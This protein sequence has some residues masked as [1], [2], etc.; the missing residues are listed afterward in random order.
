MHSNKLRYIFSVIFGTALYALTVVLFLLPADLPTGGT[1]GIALAIQH[2]TFLPISVFTFLFNTIMLISGWI[3]LGRVFA[4]T[5]VL[6][7]LTYPLALSLFQKIFDGVVL[8]SNPLLCTLYTGLGI[9]ISLAIV[10]RQG[11]STGGMDIPPLMLQKLAGIPVS[12]SLY[13]FDCLILLFQALYLPSESV[14]YGILNVL[15]Y[16]VTLDKLLLMG[17]SKTEV[18]VIS[19]KH[20][21]IRAAILK[22][23]DRGVTMLDGEGGFSHHETRIIMSIVSNRELANIERIIRRTDP[24]AFMIVSRVSEV[25]GRGFTLSKKYE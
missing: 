21:E 13:I 5:T 18:K 25:S 4:M 10:I 12:Y 19:E 22:E 20:E 6:S 24:Y 16:S 2:F 14:L 11:A 15:I 8:S 17:T 9:G 1:T 7:S 23:M 3:V